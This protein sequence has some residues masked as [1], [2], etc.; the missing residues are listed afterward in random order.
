VSGFYQLLLKKVQWVQLLNLSYSWIDWAITIFA[1]LQNG[2][3]G[4]IAAQHVD[5]EC[6]RGFAPTVRGNIPKRTQIHATF[7][8]VGKVKTSYNFCL[9]SIAFIC[10]Y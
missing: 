6:G 9:A 2:A 10:N 7:K 4:Q 1:H 8:I 3:S 5:K